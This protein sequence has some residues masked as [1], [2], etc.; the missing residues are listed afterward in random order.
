MISDSNDK[1]LK[2]SFLNLAINGIYNCFYSF[3][4]GREIQP[5]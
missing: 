2:V 5:S 3:T 4:H 1:Y